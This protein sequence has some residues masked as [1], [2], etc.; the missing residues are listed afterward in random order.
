[1][2]VF[3]LTA[4]VISWPILTGER[5]DAYALN[6]QVSGPTLRIRQGDRLRIHLT[7]QLPESTTL[8]WHGL[9]LPNAM[10]GPAEITQP[11]IPTGGQYTYEFT[12]GQ[13]GT[14]F[15]HSHDH[16]DRQQGLGLYGVLIIDPAD[17]TE[18]P[19]HDVEYTVQLQEWL[20]REGLTYPAMLMEGGL[21]NCFTINGKAY[22][23]T[24]TGPP[25]GRAEAAGALH[26]Q[27]QQLR[28]PHAHPRRAVPGGGHR[29]QP[30]RRIGAVRR[31]HR[32]RRPGSALRRHLDGPRARPV[33]A[34]LPH[35]PPHHQQQRRTG[36]C[37]RPDDDPQRD[38][39]DPIG[40][41]ARGTGRA[42]VAL[43]R[44]PGAKALVRQP[45]RASAVSCDAYG[46]G[47]RP[48]T[49][50]VTAAS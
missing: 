1:V 23:D 42:R 3:D 20:E 18:V 33:A 50:E 16:P 37:R 22:P 28:P 17:P 48:N 25:E 26:R 38:L 45:D 24:D 47:W 8:H 49:V 11:P 39:S 5:V 13:A 4:S 27:Q 19:A 14:Y 6:G 15:Y 7:N 40:Q 46:A 12:A 30:A 44:R 43:H 36:R 34:A 41:R 2:K 32:Q 35:P 10:D 29:R 9:I 21:P 31:R